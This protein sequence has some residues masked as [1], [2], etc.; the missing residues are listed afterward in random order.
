MS[1]RGPTR[2]PVLPV[3]IR[4]Q[5]EGAVRRDEG[6]D[7]GL[8]VLGV[9]VVVAGAVHDQQVAAEVPGV[10]ERRAPVVARRVVLRQAVVPLGVDGVVVLPVRHRRHRDGRPVHLR[11]LED[12]VQRHEAPVAPPPDADPGRVHPRIHTGDGACRGRLVAGLDHPHLAVDDLLER[13]A[14]ATRAAIVHAHHDVA[15]LGQHPVPQQAVPAP[16]IGHRLRAG[17]AVHREEDRVAAGGVEIRRLDHVGVEADA[18]AD[19]HLEELARRAPQRRDPRAQRVVVHQRAQDRVPRL[20]VHQVGHR[21]GVGVRVGVDREAEAR[22][23]VV[24][25]AAAGVRGREALRFAGPVEARP[26]QLALRRIAG[27]RGVVGVEPRLV[28]PEEALHVECAARH[29]AQL[30]CRSRHEVDVPPAAPIR[31]PDQVAAPVHEG[32]VVHHVHP[33]AVALGEERADRAGPRVGEQHG[34]GVLQAVEVLQH[35]LGRRRPS[36]H[37][38]RP[39]HPRDVGVAR[40]AGHRHPAGGTAGGAHDADP[41]GGVRL[42]GLRVLHREDRGVQR[43]GVVDEGEV[44]H[45]AG[46]ELPVRDRLAVRAPPPP[47]A[48]P[49]LLLV[50]PVEGAIDGGAGAVAGELDD[51]AGGQVFD[52][53]VELAHVADAAPVRRELREHQRRGPRRRPAELPEPPRSAVEDPVVP[54]GIRAPDGLGVGEDEDLVLV[55]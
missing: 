26:P 46:I 14:P 21:R 49:Q 13:P 42:P 36:A 41:S 40:V 19:V 54:A 28:H 7:H 12:A 6:V 17:A 30:A 11:E 43:V 39:L 27:G 34:D 5:L 9:H 52:V 37:G 22:R 29:G 1:R 35:Q 4:H 48:Q 33:G 15:A 32:E 44:A 51:T 50:H 55:G 18:V 3:G 25:V 53:E 31:E 47:V 8:G 2:Y 23:H 10:G 20:Q 16:A 45:A 24:A 38:R